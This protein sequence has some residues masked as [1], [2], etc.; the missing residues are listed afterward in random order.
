MMKKFLRAVVTI[1]I[2][3]FLSLQSFSQIVT[4]TQPNQLTAQISGSAT[5][6]S[7]SSATITVVISGGTQTWTIVYPGGSAT[8]NNGSTSSYTYTFS[9]GVL[10]S[11]TTYNSG[12][13]ILSD[14]NGCSTNYVGSATITVNPLPSATIS[15]TATVCLN[16]PNPLITFTGSNGVAPYTFYYRVNSGAETSVTTSSGNSVTVPQATSSAGA[17]TYTLIR[18]SDA[19]C[20]N[21]QTGS[22]TVT[23]NPNNSVSTPSSNPLVYIN[24]AI[25]DITFSTTGATGINIATGLPSGVSA[26]WNSNTITI[27]GTPTVSGV[28][29]YSI[30]LSGGCGTVYAT[31]TITVD[32]VPLA[33]NDTFTTSEDTPYTGT[34]ATNDTPSGDGGNVWSKVSDPLHGALSFNADGSFTYTPTANYNGTDSFDYTITDA[35][36]DVSTATVTITINSVDD[37]PVAVNDNVSTSEDTPYTGTVSTNDS[38]SGDGG[39]VWAKVSDPLHGALSFSADGSFTYTPTANYNGTDS[40]DYRIT[41]ADGDVSTATVTITVNS[42]DDV[43]VAVNDNVSTSEDTPYTGTVSTNDS[44]SGDGGNVWA[45]V[46]D[47]LHGA[48]SFSADGSFTY[49]PTAN[50]NGTD[51]FDYRITDADGDVST[52]TVTITVNSVD[53]VPVAVND[54]VSTSEDTPYTGTV[55]TNDT[56]SG[57]GGNV[58]SKVSD[59][60]HGALSFSADGSFTYTPTANYNGTDSFDYTITDADGDVSTATV[61]ITVNSVDDVPVAVN[62]NVSTSEDT[63]YTG[64][65][66]TNDSPSGDGGNVWAKVSDPL[67]GALSFN[68]DGSFTYTPTANYNG[69]DSFDYTITDADGDVSTATVTITVNSVDDVPVAVNDNVSTN[70]DTALTSNVSTNDTPSGDGGNVWAKVSD[71]LHGALSFNADGSFTYTPTANYNGTD[72]FDYTITDA[73]GDVSTATVT[74]TVNSVDDVPVAVNDNVSTSEDTPYTGTVSTNDTPSGDGGNVWSKVSDP[75]HGALSF[76][77]DGSFTYTPTANYNGTDSFDYTITDADGDVSTA[78]VTIT[79]NSVDDAPLAVN[80][81]VSTSEDTPYTGTVSTNDTPSGDGGNVWS[82]VSDPLHGALSFNADGSFTYTPTANYNGTDSFDYTITDADGDVSTATVTITVNS[83]DD[84]PV[85]VNDNVSTN[86]DTALSSNVSTNDSPSGDGGNVWSKVSDPLHGALSFNADGSFTY[87]P[88]A[89][90]NG[91]DSFDYTIT[92]ADGDVSTATVT[93]TVNSVD[94]APLAVNDNVSTSED[95]PY[96]GTVSTNDTPSGDGGNVWSK[97]SDPLHGA[98]SFNADG[99]FT[100]T[101]TANYNG[102]DSF[103]YT[104]TDADGDVSTATVT[105]TVNSV[106]DAPLAVNDNVSTSE[107]TPY[108]GTVSTNDTPSGDGGNVWSKVS[109]PLHGALSFNADG[110]FTYTPTANY[111]GT[112][113]FDYTITDADGDVSTAT[114]TITVNSVDDVPVAV[115]DNVS[116]SEDTPYTGTV[117]TNDSPSGDGGNVWSKVSDPL[118]GALSFN[119]DGSFTYTPTAN[120]N[121]ADSFD[122]TITDADGDVST[123]TVTI[124]VN[125]VDDVPVAVNDNVSTNEDTALS[126]NVSTNDSPSGDGGNVWAKVS[127]PL[128]GALSFN[129]DG[130]FTYTPTA[131]YN[132][133][134][135][136]DYTITDADGDVSTATVTITVN[137]VDDVPVA[138]NDNVSTSEDTPYTGTVATNDSP[139]GDG[140]NVWSKVSD[141]LHGA[142]S[143]NADGSFTYTPTANYNGTDSFDYTITDADGDVSTATVTITVNSVDDAPLAVNDNVSTSEDTPYTGTAATNDSPSGD[144]GNVWAKVSD[145]LHGALSFNADGSFTYTPTANYNGTDSFDYTITDADGD[146]STATVTITVNSVDDVP[147]AVNDNVSTSEDT[148]LTS[149]VSTNDSPSGDG[150]NVW[151]KVS[152]PLHGALSF[153]ADGSFTYT[154]TANYNGSD[155]FDYTI[156]DADGDVSTATVT[157][158]VNSVD[159][160]PLAVNDNVSTNEDTAL[161][162]NVSTND[163]PSGDGGNVWSKVSD[164]LHGALSF[165]ADGS[166]TYTPTANYNGTDSFDYTITD[167]DGDVSTATVTITVNSVDDVPVAVNDN[168]STS[169]DTPYTGTVATNDSPS[170]DGGN[171]WAKVSDPLH[172]A[173]SFSA[174]GSF[175]YTPTANYNGTD[176]FDYTITDADGDVSTATVTITVNSVDDAPL[177]VNDNVSTSEDTPYTGTVA[178]NDSPSGDG[179]NVWSKVSDPLHGAL[180]F[181]ADGSF[182][183]TP[184]ANY[185]GTDSF[186]YTITDADGDVSTATVTITVNS[187]DDVPVAVNDNVSTSEDTPYTG[188][189]ATNDSPSGDGGNVWSKVSDPLHGALSFNA[190]GS[191]TYTP[192]ANYNGTDSFD[193]TITDADGDVSTAT[194]TIT[195]NSVDDAPLA[196]NDNVSTS[197]DTPYTGTAATNDSPSGDGGNVWSK[198]SDPLHGALSFSADGSFTYTPT[199]NYNGTDSFD[200]TITD[201]D[202]DVSTATVTITVNSVDDVPVAVNDNVSTSEDT[203]YTG[204][205]STNDTPS[206]DGGNVWSKVSDPLHGALSFSADGSFTYTPTANYN[207]TD[208]FDYTITDA[209]GDVSTATVTITVNSVDDVPVAV[210]DNVSTSEDTP[211]TGTVATNDSPSGDGGNVWA[212]VSDPL[213]GALSFNADGSFTYTPTA[214]YNGTDSFDYTITD[215]DGDVSTATVTITVN[216]VDDVPVAVNDNVS[217]SEDTPYTGTVATNDSPSGDGGNVWSKVSDPLHGALSFNADGSFTYT[218]AANYNGTDSFDYTITDADGDV[219]TATVTI[220]V[221]SVDDAPLAVNDN[222][223]T[224]EDTALTSNVSTNDSPSGDGGNVWSKVS[225]PLHG[226]LSFNAD[227]SFTYTPTANYNGTDSFDYT[228]TDADGDVSTATV[229]ITINSVDDVPV[230][231]NDNVSTSE[232]TPYTGTVSTNDSPSGDGGNVWAKV[233]DPLHGALSFS[234][235]GS[236]T[237]TPT[238]NYNGTD[239]FDYRITDADGD[240][241]TAT[242]TI[243][244]N[245]VDDVPVAVNDNVST[246]E[247][248]PYTGTVSTNDTPSGDGGNVWSKVSDPLHGALSFSADGSFTYTPTANYN[249][250]DSF[251]YTITDADGD[252]STATV[253]IT[254]N[255]V[256]DVPVAV[257]D[258]VSTSE[259]TPYTGTVATNDS[260]SGDGGNVWAKVSDPLHGALSFNADGSFTYTPTANYNGTDSFDYTITDAD[261]D[262][263]T[264]TVTITVNSVDDVPVAVNDN[265]S[266]NEDTAL[267]SNVSTNDTPSGDGGNVWAK[268]SDPLHGALSFNADGSFTYTPTANYNGTDSFDY[269]ITDADGDVSTATVTIT[270]NSVD[271]VPVAVNDNVSTSEDTPYTGTVSTNDT[272]SG[273]GGNVW[274]KVS[275]PLHGALSFNADGSFTY[276]PTANYNGTDSFDYTITDA[277][278]DVSTATVTITVNSVDDAP[279]AVNDNVST[280]E[281][282]PY[283]GTAATNDSPSGDGGNV[284]AKVSDPLHGALSFNADGSFTYTPTANYN[285]TDSFD[286]TITDADGDVSTATVTI[287]VNSVDDVPVAVNDNVSTSEDTALTSNVSTND[288]PSGDGGNVW[289]KVSDPLHGALSFNADGSFTYTPTANYNGTDSFDYT[290][291]DADGDVST[292]TVTITVNSVDDVPVAVNDNVSTSEDTALT[293]NVS[294]NDSPS[295]DGGN[296]WSKVSDPLHG[297]LSF[298][299]DGS[300]TYT[301]TANYNG[302]DSF[303]YTITDADGDVSTATVT[304]TVNSVDDVPVAVNDNV[305][306]SEDTPYTGTVATNDSPSGDGGNVWAKVSDPLH[307]ALSFNADG[308]F[309]YTPTANYNGTDSFDYTIT[310]ADGDVSTATV[311]ITVNSV[312]DVPVAVNDNVS[313]NEDT[314]LTS[315]VSTNDTPSGDGGNVWAKVS[316]PLHGALSFNADGSFTYTPTANYNGTDSFDYTITDADGDVSTATV[317]ITVNSVDDVPVAVN[318][319]VSTSEDTPYT[320]TVSTNDTPSGDGGNVWSKVSD[321]LHGALSFNADGSFTYTPTANYNGTDSFDYTITDADGDVSTATVTITVNSVD[322]APLAVNDNVSTS[323]DTPYTGTVATNDSPSGDG[324]NVWSKVSDPLHGALS[325]NADGSFTYTPTANYNGADSFDYTITDADGDVSTATVTITVNS[326]DDVPVAVNDNVSTNED[327]ALSSNVSTNDSPSGDGGNVWAKVS[328]PL[329]GALSFNADGSFTYTPTANYNGTDSFDYTI[330]DADGDVSTAT[331]T[332]TV[333]SVDDV[334]VAVNDN[335]STSEDTPYTGTV[336]T[337]DSP[338][339]DGGNV[340]SKVSDPLHGALSFNADGSFT[341]TPTANYNGTDSF[342]YT[343]TDADGD[344]STAT[345]TITVNS[346]DDVPVAVNDNVSTS[347][348]TPYTGTVS[349]NDTPSGDGGNVWSKVSDPLHGALS[350]NADGSFTYTPTANYNGTDS[351]DYTITDADGDVSTA[352]VTITVNSVDDA[353]LAVNDN[354]STSEDTPYTG[355]V[356]TNDTPSGDGGNV[357]SKVS[358]PLHG[359]LSFNADGSFTYTPTANYNGTDSFDYTITDADGDVSTATV[360][361]TVNSVDD[362]PVAVNDNVSTNED[363]ALS[364]NVST[365]DTPSGDGGNVWSKVSDPLHGALSFNADGSF[366]Y[367]PTANYNGTDSFDYTITDAD[368]DVSTATVTITVNSVDDVPVAVNDNVSTSEDTALTS[369]VSTNDSPSGDGGNVW[370]KVSDPLHGALSFNADGSFTYTPTANY[371][372]TDSFDYTITDADGDVSTATVTI[373]VNSVDDVPVAVND[374][375]STN[376]DTALSSNVSTNDSPS[377]DGGNVWAKVSD[378]LHGALSF[379]ADGSFTYTPTANYNGTDSFDYTITDADGDVSTATVTI[380]VNSVD[381]VP[382]AVNDNVSTSEDTPYTGTVA[383]NDTPSGDGGNVWS[384][385]SDPLHGALSFNADGSFTYTPT[386]NYNGTDSFDYTITDADGDVSTATVT[387]TVNSVDDVPVA[388]NDNVSTSEDTALTSNVSTNDSPSGDGGNVWSKVSDPLHGALSFNADGSFTYTPT[389]NYNGT[390]SFDYTITDADGDVSTATVTITVNSVDDVPVAVNDNVSTNE[391]TALSSNVSTNDSPSGDGG[392]V[393]A[394]VSDPL[395]GAL[396]FNADGS[397]TYTPTAN[398]NGTDSFDYT[399]TD[400]DGD[401]S[402]ATVTITVNSVDD[403]PVAVNDNVSTSEDTPYTGTVATNDSPSGDGGNVWSKVSDPLHGALSFNADGSFTYTPTANYNGADSFDYTI[404]DADGDVS[405]ATVT[406]TVNSVDDVPVAVNDNVSTNEDTALSSNVSTNDSP[407]GDGGN[408]WAKV[409]DPLHGALSFN[410]DG[411]FTY[412]PTANYNGTDSFDYTITDAD[413]DVSTATV[414]ITVNSVD[415]VPVAVNDNV[416]TSEDTPYTGTV[417]TNDSPSGDGGNVWSKVSDPLHGALSFNADGSFTYTPTAN[418]NGTDSFDYTITDADGDVS[419]A[420]VTITVNSVDD[421]PLAVNDNVST[422]EDTPYTGTA[423]TNDSPSG[424]GGNVWAKVSDPLHG[425]LSFNADG[426]FTY[427]PT[428]NYNGTDSFDYTITD[429]DGDVSTATVTITVNSVDDVP[430]AVNDNV[431]TSEDTALT[432]NV[433]TNDSPSGDGGN[434]WS[435]VSDPLHGALSFNA[436]GSFTYTPTANYNGSDSFDYTITDADGDVSTATVTITVNSVDDAPLAVNDNVST[437]EDT[438]LTSNVSTNDSPSGDGGNVWAK[439]SDPLHGALSF[440]ADGSFTYTP[441]A[442]YNGTDSFDY[443]ITD[444]DGDVSTATV[445]ITVN[446]VDD[447]PVAVNDNV[448]TNEDTALTS[449]V[450]TNDTPSGDGGNVWAKVSDP[451]HGA[452]SFNADGSF[453]YTPTANYNGTDSFD[454]TITDADGDVSTATVTITVNS[455]DDVPVAVNDNVSTSEDTPYTGTVATNDSPSGDGGNVWSKVSDPLHGAL[456]FNADGSFTYTPTA[457]YNG[458]DSFDYTITDADGDVSTATV[459]IT[460]NSVDDAPLAVNDNVSTSEDTPY[461][462]TVSTNDT[463][464][465]DGGNVWSKVSDPLHGALSF[466]ADGSFTYTPTANYN[467]TDSF[468]YTITDADGDVSTATVTI[469]VNSVDDVPVAVNDNVSTSED[470]PYTGTVATNDSP[471]GDGGN[472]WSK[473]SDPLHGA[474]SFNADG[475]FTYTPTA[476]YNGAD[477]FDYT[478]TDADGDVSTATVTITVNSVDDAP[479]AVNDNVST[480]EDTPYTG[481]AATNDSPSGDGG[482]VWAKVSDPLHGALSFNADGSFTY[483][484]TAN[485]NGTDSFDYTITDA[486]GDV[487]TATVTITVNSVDDVPVAVN[488]NVSTS[489]DTALTSNVSTNDSP[490]GD[491]GNV[492]SKVSDPLHGALSFNADGSFTYTPTANYNGSDSFDYTITDADGDVSTA[493]V[494]ITVNSVD[495]VPVAVND[496]VSTSEDTPY[497]GTVATNDSPSGD[498]GNVWSKVSDPLH[499]ALSFSTDGSFTYT[500]AANY[501]GTDSF[502]YTITDADGDVSTATVTITVNSVDDAPLAVND[503][504]STNEDTALTSNVS[505]NDSPSGDGGNVWSKVSDPLHGALSFNADGSFTYT[506]TA[507]YNGTDSFDYT[508]TDAD[509]DV[510]TATVTITINSV[511]DVPVAVN[512]NVSTSEDTPYTGTVSTNDSPSGDGGNVWA[513]VSDPLHGALSFSADGSFTYT[514]TANYNGT[515]SFDYRITDADG[516]VSTATV[517]ITVNSVDDVPVAVN[518]N[519]STSEDTPYTGTVSTNDSPSGDGG[520]VWAKVSD[521]LHG[522][523]SFSADG[524]FTYTPTANY[525]GT[526]SFDYRITDADGDV[527]TATVT[528]TVNSVDDVPVAVNDNV[529]TSEDTPYTGTVSTNDTPSGDGGNV[530]SKVSDPLHGALSFSADG[531]FTYT[532]TANYNGTDSFDYTIT[533]ADG[534]VSTATVTITVNSVDDVPVAV[535]DNVSTSED[536]PYTGT[537]AT[538]DSPSGDGGNVWAK[539]SDPLHGALS[540]NADGS[541]TYTPTANYNGTDSFD[542]TITDADGDVSTATVTITVNSVDDV[543][544][545]VNDNVSTSEDTPYTGTVS[546]ND[547]PSGDGGNVWSKVSDPLHG[548][549]SFNADGSFTYT[550]TANYNGTDSFDYTITDADGDVSTAT[551]T[552]TVNSVDDVP[553]AVNDNVSTSEDT[554]YTGTVATNDS[555]SGDGGNV[556]AKVSDPLHGALSFSADGSFTYTPT[557]NYNGTDSF[558]YTI[559]DADGDV[560]TAT[561]TITV[562]SV[563]DVPVAVN[564]NVSTSEDTPYTGTVATNDS[565]SGDGGNVWSKVS[566]P[567]HGALSFSTDGSFTYTPAANYNGTDSFDYTITDSDGDVS[568]ATVTITISS[569][570]D[571]PVAADDINSTMENTAVS[572]DVSVNDTLSGDGGNAWS[573]VTGP[574]HGTINMT[575][576]GG[577]TYTPTTSWYGTETITYKICD[578][579]GDCSMATLVITVVQANV[580][581]V[582]FATPVS[583]MEDTPVSGTV[584]ATD[585]NGDVLTFSKV[586]NPSHGIVSV[587]SD[588]HFIYTPVTNYN[589]P[590]SFVV[591]VNDGHGGTATGTVLVTVIPVNDIPVAYDDTKIIPEDTQLSSNIVAFDGDGDVLTFTKVSDTIHG[592]VT[593]DS[594]G[595]YTYIP[596]ANYYG[597]D[598]FTVVVTDGHGGTATSVITILINPVNDAPVAHDDAKVTPENTPVSGTVTATDVDGDVLTF[599][600][601]IDPAHGTATVDANGHYSYSPA[602][603]YVG[604]DKFTISVIDGNGGFVTV[605]IS[606]TVTPVNHN[607]IAVDD[608]VSTLKGVPVNGDVKINDTLSDDGGNVFSLVTNPTNGSVSLTNNGLFTYTPNVGYT[609]IDKFIYRLCDTN[610]DCSTATVT[611]SVIDVSIALIKTSTIV[612]T[613]TDGIKGNIGDQIKY[614]FV[615]TNTGTVTLTSILVTDPKVT[616][617]GGPITLAA[618]AVDNTSFFATY[619]IT[620]ADIQNGSVTNQ[621]KVEGKDVNGKTA[622]DLSDEKSNKDNNPTVTPVAGGAIAIIK[623][624][625]L[626]DTNGDGIKGNAG[627]GIKYSFT[628]TNT[629]TVTLTNVVISDPKVAVTGA[630]ITLI[631]GAVDKTTFS[632]TYTITTT[633]IQNGSVTNQAVAKGTDPLGNIISDLSDSSDNTGNNPTVTPIAGGILAII[634]TDTVID[635]N[636]DGFVGNTGD[637]IKYSFTVSNIGTVT[638]TD[639]IVTDTKVSVSGGPITLYA[640]QVDNT[641]F[642]AI[643]TITANDMLVGSVTN[644]AKVEGT[645]IIGNKVSDLSDSSSNTSNNPTVTPLASGSVALIKTATIIDVNGDGIKGNVGDK[646][647]YAFVVTNTGKVRLTNVIVTDPKVTVTGSP[648]SLEA[649]AV[650]KTSFTAVYTISSADLIAGSVINQ[651]RVDGVD[652]LGNKVSD[653]SDDNSNTEN[654]PTV[655]DVNDIP[656][657]VNDEIEL[658]LDQVLNGYVGDNDKLSQDGGN[659]W[660]L[661]KQPAKG[662][663]MFNP[664]GSYIYTPLPDFSGNDSFTY[665]LCDADGDCSEATVTIVVADIVPDQ[666]FTPNGDSQNDT[667]FIKGIDRYPSN[668]VTILNRWGN[669][670][671]EKVG[672]LNEWD[673]Y[674]NVRKVGKE[675]LPVGTYYYLIQYG[676]NRHKAGFV[677]LER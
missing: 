584:S 263:S 181:N 117:A 469:T 347:E 351:F 26:I 363:T 13:I 477:S 660:S 391:D 231:V 303:D 283:T 676:N 485:Y 346:V 636:G 332:I 596:D 146:V 476:N 276:T 100:Y 526:D 366:T 505:T 280:S 46:S 292:A 320:G 512:D 249:G 232:D 142:L 618:G 84:V 471:S 90:Y 151:S 467:G 228:I 639:V 319:N 555:P 395:H 663:L 322:D 131:N 201:A 44:P 432:S 258:N 149:N 447:V 329:H 237:Y 630:P 217:T 6:C 472:V 210:N 562:N 360:T 523:L 92:D 429:A 513:K 125:S 176:S 483:T 19:N 549:L 145:P 658:P 534:D 408:V 552:I 186:D 159:D 193:Y 372:G 208:S 211:Y 401:V 152:D 122:Y 393:W 528:I 64:T 665:K 60:L 587:D 78:T 500:P 5:I 101:P 305:S 498:G 207:G 504:V 301:P 490:S 156:T 105:I 288:S 198:V 672:Y 17:F 462:G 348:D 243:T 252:V 298:S 161:T 56:P 543:P 10:T 376:E 380:T 20:S 247:D 403:V 285:G 75:L 492:W 265:V 266:T 81:N 537:V 368:G 82:K 67:H 177:A 254:V 234:A 68:A 57:D 204:T 466:N 128:H 245:S 375:V 218:P 121:G 271:D 525:N 281:D 97:V 461:T 424:D 35:D 378:P 572:G 342:D 221:N 165:S 367:T 240:V 34:V 463:P 107:D 612:D 313:T 335:V 397:F 392:N 191:F 634:K 126:S 235:D 140:G 567:L 355:T 80:D 574:L 588:G 155:S 244:V 108:T 439:V 365:N 170:G 548:A 139:S 357:W 673:G 359:A 501:N 169:E 656:V 182:T 560:S 62:D 219:S 637:Q 625:D 317:T 624:A 450:S 507:N 269:T 652:L 273:D 74:I 278:G 350:F 48:L 307:G 33:V 425:A 423:A 521:P 645:D 541:F 481:T 25:P 206:G 611:I 551:V 458:T 160:A 480:S 460:V 605:T 157:I 399:I 327:T 47:P 124:T 325:F 659:T 374:N 503:N 444:A 343:I 628:V 323:E 236:F 225:D 440:N 291:T 648:I 200:Y 179:G 422:S 272:P 119:A 270:V 89:N 509:G 192:T 296:V 290:I 116:T 259:D 95:T 540:F 554:P 542:Y 674:S 98:L 167:A 255:S 196:V 638:L 185:N 358:D 384:K 459:T 129:A 635:A 419:T 585:A 441:T 448:S 310:D 106:D 324:G 390:D 595:N 99:S 381:D 538:N 410:A 438:A 600:K 515:D 274:S 499:G 102:T 321:P 533:D 9:T 87:T 299:A 669:I 223:S 654:D 601:G 345:V 404:T 134:D 36:G 316:D 123:A 591:S 575:A 666:V 113:S 330:T 457:N 426:S 239:S 667:Y 132:G 407:S 454:Y 297:A 522:A 12:N 205:V 2:L 535:N 70:E 385:V 250:T 568:T 453:T 593:V 224:N 115:N 216:S 344:V 173:L 354:V 226:A 651:A 546:T 621:A 253:T 63:P 497:T 668:K 110:S 153:N 227:G 58:W 581:P 289:S 445:T 580:P 275:D 312:D 222:V 304:I 174:D 364:S 337:N 416:S 577:Y 478:I 389:A 590:D 402:T 103:D 16:N 566:D 622:T 1:V 22:S 188:T 502:D 473:V 51:S 545:A 510:S 613:N 356:S 583:T 452:L 544:V 168:V 282:T 547:T 579:D 184:T 455:V 514:P 388:V 434:V 30:P 573:V 647:N 614:S 203:P 73:D 484:P 518:D 437:N 178:T 531:S 88:T 21:I 261:G 675:P 248:T 150:G 306:T 561:V 130:S 415:D 620:T 7:G 45:K 79:V 171:V 83:V 295:G 661:V 215:A 338:S 641:T 120:Y 49:T 246:S 677:Y 144:G 602:T 420:T 212:K 520:N 39:N 262:V 370:S 8:I 91:T 446:S 488:D 511:D 37:V 187:V 293:S 417:A 409:S 508:I 3:L 589:G 40:F 294:T 361:I 427:T 563:D 373:T 183:Y 118:H 449:N 529:S 536:T 487:S 594:N 163:S 428:A 539:V 138:V 565:P 633:D 18:V 314:A 608:N 578:S 655:T 166:F 61:T 28:F 340:W 571:Q 662:T 336:A 233:S 41:D 564:D 326:V 405:T 349:T 136:F 209:D 279:L 284:W 277:D 406:I 229:T 15:G 352:T 148:A 180:S 664:D 559:T 421:A 558:D 66:A 11:T 653:L 430:V 517:T 464:S 65:V 379:N 470:T 479:L 331:V 435:K 451:L 489:E 86:E 267:T 400:A 195:V 604:T 398:Y 362:V 632:A 137:S 328:D 202:G 109:D 377:G 383:T 59:P 194:V 586:S 456:S 615:V 626:I 524:S 599:I 154:P 71:P 607:P 31:G 197:E 309:T 495:D 114:V 519:V 135:S 629:G 77:A 4:I 670:V 257:N 431:S 55:S 394:K 369:N 334:P 436:D 493:T 606:I 287:T 32:G 230:A 576:L 597:W 627:D 553:V 491:G 23:V 598:T 646:I 386:A 631:S 341:Y 465:G 158:T 238:A 104:I 164:P 396:S 640:G 315:N 141:P 50:Y 162:S 76:N 93:I 54:N 353:P 496:N 251:D 300:F 527:S 38:P 371:N 302:T 603:N 569:V 550:P 649:G 311:T 112:D 127:D 24:N 442:N 616:V 14:S 516:D 94:D 52:A 96:T 339:G 657:A 617:I 42:V 532:P 643:Y 644:Q 27:S 411:S 29:N 619:T 268:V 582:I 175:T 671:Y 414:T 220:T 556:W 609:G 418:Y 69:T 256:D 433:S 443:T 333:N 190:D 382:V 241:S 387:I 213:H 623:T 214:N 260:P 474:L 172:G 592:T 494:T 570:D 85:A 308:S 133:T 111:N 530:W 43:P 468:D 53:D 412:T 199:A 557:A 610:G 242:V 506:P 264:A 486:D 189:V 650:D 286:Y 642:N 413:G 318:D 72:S 147:V 143:F 475:S 482:N